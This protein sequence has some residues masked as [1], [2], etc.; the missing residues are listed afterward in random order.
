MRYGT[1]QERIASGAKYLTKS[2]GIPP[3][4]APVL[5]TGIA[6]ASAVVL[7]IFTTSWRQLVVIAGELFGH[8]LRPASKGGS[9][10]WGNAPWRRL[11]MCSRVHK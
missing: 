9:Q 5:D 7:A 2:N 8:G 4:Y 11:S 10:W 1:G 6:I 3:A